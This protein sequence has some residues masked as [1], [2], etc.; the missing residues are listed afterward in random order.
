MG[1]ITERKRLSLDAPHLIRQK[2]LIRGENRNA[3]SNEEGF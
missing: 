2:V 3:E 1:N